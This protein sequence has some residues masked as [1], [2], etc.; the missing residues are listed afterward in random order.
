[1]CIYIF[2]HLNSFLKL[3]TCSFKNDK[4]FR[5]ICCA[6]ILVIDHKIRI[7]S[8]LWRKTCLQ[9]LNNSCKVLKQSWLQLCSSHKV[10]VIQTQQ[11]P[12]WPQMVNSHFM[13]TLSILMTTFG[14]SSQTWSLLSKKGAGRIIE[15]LERKQMIYLR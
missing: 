1:M 13:A 5:I 15:P 6:K 7:T 2:Q 12:T 4:T 3:S 9:I 8:Y 14:L 10:T 11:I